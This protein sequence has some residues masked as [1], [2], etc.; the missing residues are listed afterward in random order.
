MEE[1]E[2]SKEEVK[3]GYEPAFDS[4]IHIQGNSD[5]KGENL[6]WWRTSVLGHSVGFIL[7]SSG[8]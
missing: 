7:P 5:H 2:D 4:L 3:R 8:L 1:K 6:A